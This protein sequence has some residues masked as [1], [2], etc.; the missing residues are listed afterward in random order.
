[1]KVSNEEADYHH[2][3]TVDIDDIDDIPE[4]ATALGLAKEVEALR[5]VNDVSEEGEEEEEEDTTIIAQVQ[6][7]TDPEFRWLD[8]E[9]PTEREFF[10]RMTH[11]DDSGMLELSCRRYV[12]AWTG[13][14]KF[15]I[16]DHSKI[17][18]FF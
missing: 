6:G 2:D 1:M 3:V 11:I 10:A 12:Y 8:P 7:D 4:D 9:L 18:F 16:R 5:I 15:L 14:D 17:V 13:S